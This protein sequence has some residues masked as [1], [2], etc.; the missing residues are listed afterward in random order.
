MKKLIL[1]TAMAMVVAAGAY[2]QGLIAIDN[3]VNTSNNQ[4][5]TSGGLFWKGA[6]LLAEDANLTLLGGAD[7]GSLAPLK[8]FLLSNGSA[9]GSSAFGAGT[10]TDLSGG[11]Y[12]VAGVAAGAAATLQV[13]IW[14]GNYN[15]YAAAVA[16]GAYAGQSTTFTQTL[17]GGNLVPPDLTGMPAVTLSQV[18]VPEP[19]T[20]ALAGLGAAALLIFRRRS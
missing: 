18:P 8:T 4:A 11:T 2:A 13:Q 19:S 17:G 1:S 12:A 10:W 16:A 7:A 5:A 14:L 20:I 6:S 3:N 9:T 15:T